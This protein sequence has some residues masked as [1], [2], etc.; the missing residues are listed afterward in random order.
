MLE[1]TALRKKA[2]VVNISTSV[3][4]SDKEEKRCEIKIKPNDIQ[5]EKK[6]KKKER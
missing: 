2:K 4:E 5:V 3:T 1:F 6:I